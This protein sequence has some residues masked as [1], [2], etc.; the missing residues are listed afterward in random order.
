MINLE[1][2]SLDNEEEI[3]SVLGDY[4]AIIAHDGGLSLFLNTPEGCEEDIP[5]H[6]VFLMMLMLISQDKEMVDIARERFEARIDT[7]TEH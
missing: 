1:P 4:S 7:H 3:L 6:D 5:D 2:P